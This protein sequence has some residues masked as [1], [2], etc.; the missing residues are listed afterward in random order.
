LDDDDDEMFI[1]FTYIRQLQLSVY[2]FLPVHFIHIQQVTIT[3]SSADTIVIK[4][5][6]QDINKKN[7]KIEQQRK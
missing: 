6:S 2:T 3:M 7:T 1:P 4:A 5:N